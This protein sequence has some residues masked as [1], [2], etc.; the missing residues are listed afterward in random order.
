[1]RILHLFSDWKWTG[2]AEPALNLARAQ[3][4]MG[5][6]VRFVCGA[7]PP[8]A[9]QSIAEM[10][11]RSEFPVETGLR[12]RKHSKPLANFLD[13]RAL[14]RMIREGDFGVVHTHRPND[15]RIGGGAARSV[16]RAV[17]V[18]RTL[19]A[20]EEPA[21]RRSRLLLERYTDGLISVSRALAERMEAEETGR[22]FRIAHIP[23]AVDLSRFHPGVD[24]RAR[25]PDLGLPVD[26]VVAGVV[27]RMQ[28]HR[29]FEVLLP[30]IRQA[31]DRFDAL[32][33]VIFGRGTN[34]E[35]VAIGPARR[36]G[37]ADVIRFPGYRDRDYVES[38]AA[39]DFLI[40]LVPGSDGSCRA[41]RESMALGRPVL[42][43]RR[44]MLPEIVD[45][46]KSGL[47]VDDDPETLTEA[48]L[49]MARD[50]EGRERMGAE[51]ARK[52]RYEFDL[53]TQAEAVVS[54]YESLEGKP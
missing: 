4:E 32:R 2:P 12:M 16:P 19:Y 51:A 35:A 38:L 28:H 23:G 41:V 20:P 48:I 5:H 22:P 10:A 15:H 30:A 13:R 21:G 24:G 53:G 8:Q 47:V 50:R 1:M 43:A 31:H 44:G 34:R 9:E 7:P 11:G 17:R 39:I 27:A 46:G 54:F 40:F 52:A 14:A 49:E 18:V 33:V 29:R 42:A 26:A 45:H 3:S 6:T 25:R 37:L 36:M